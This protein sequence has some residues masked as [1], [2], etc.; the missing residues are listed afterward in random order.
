MPLVPPSPDRRLTHRFHRAF[1]LAIVASLAA[2]VPA[3]PQF[4]NVEV[5]LDV[6]NQ[7]FVSWG[8]TDADET[9]S[10]SLIADLNGDGIG[11]LV[12]GIPGGRGPSDARG[13]RT[14]EI[15][16]RFGTK[17][18][19]TAEDLFTRP[20]DV[21]LYGVDPGDQLPRSL[22]AGDLNG[23]GRADLVIG[24]SLADG[25]A[26]AR[27]GCGEVLVL[28]GRAAWPAEIDL[29]NVD[30]S[31]TNADVT[32]FGEEDGDQFG[33]SVA[34]GDL[35]GDGTD[36]LAVGA[37]GADGATNGRDDS[38]KAYVFYGGALPAQIDL[39]NAVPSVE[40]LGRDEG[41]LSGRSLAILDFNGDGT[42][43]LAI[44]AP[45]GDGSA[46]T[47]REDSGEVHVLFG[48]P[49]LPT[50]V[51]LR[52]GSNV[53]V[54]GA[55]EADLA[56]SS[57]AGGNLNGDVRGDLVVGSPFADGPPSIPRSAAGEVA[58]V[59]G[60]ETPAATIDLATAA[61]VRVYGA[62]EGDQLGDA[63][64]V[65]SLDGA[66]VYF[67]P[68][69][70]CDVE[71]TID[72]L[73]MTA[74]GGDGPDG[75]IPERTSAGEIYV[76]LGKDQEFA[77]FP[78]SY[79]LN[80]F[81]T[82]Q[83]DALFYGRDVFDS[84][85][86]S[87]ATGDADGDGIGEI[88][89]GAADGDGPEDG[90]GGGEDDARPA[91]GEAWL[92]S[93]SD[94]DGD[95]LRGLGDNCPEDYNPNQFDSD[96]DGVGNV[97]DNCLSAA[98]P[99]QANNDGDSEGDA[100]DL[101]DDNDGI[102]DASDPCPFDAGSNSDPDGDGFGD[103][104]DNCPAVPNPGQENL[105]GDVEGDACDA[106]DD[107][108][109]V[110]DAS[111]NCPVVSN[112]DQANGDADVFGDVCDNCASATNGGQEDGDADGDGD[113]C[114]NCPVVSNPSQ[115][116]TDG[117][118]DGDAC[119]NCP[120]AANADQLDADADGRGDVCD[121]CSAV[122]NLDQ[123]DSDLDGLGNACD[124]CPLA[125]N[126]TQTD[127][128]ADGR[129][130]ACDNCVNAANS[131]QA[132]LDGDSVG[133]VCDTDRDG[134]AATND[135][136]NCP[137]LANPSQFNGDAD[138]LGD[139]CDNCPAV[140]N[141][142]Q[143]DTDGDSFG[144][145][146][147]NC[148][149]FA[150][151]NQRNND[152]DPLGDACDDDDDGDGV[153]DPADNCPYASNP[154]QEDDDGDGFGNACDFT[155]IDLASSQG[156]V[157][158][159][160]R[161]PADFLSNAVL[162]ADVDGDGLNDLIFS[163]TAASGPSNAR[164]NAGE[165]NILFGRRAW[166][167]E[168]DLATT[169]PDVRIFGVDAKDSLGGAMAAGDFNGDGVAD[170]AIAARF[171]DGASN[172]KPNAG[173]VY[174]LFGRSRA[175][176]PATID[177]KSADASRSNADVT[178]F[179][180]DEGDQAGRSLAMGDVNGD[181]F[182]DVVLGATGG[183][184]KNN[185]CARCGD[186][187]IVAG[188]A[189]PAATYDLA[190]TGG[191]TTKLFG[192]FE[193][194][195]FGWSVATLDFDGDGL[196][197]VAVGALARD[198]NLEEDTGRVYVVRGASNLP[199]ERNMALGQFLVA[200]DGVDALDQFG[201]SLA[202]GEF[203]DRN[204]ACPPCEDLVVGAPTGDGPS[205]SDFRQD[206]G[207]VFVLRGRSDLSA[208]TVFDL[209]AEADPPEN[210]LVSIHGARA[211][212]RIG[213]KV[214]AGDLDG[215]LREDV[216]IGAPLSEVDAARPA[217]GRAVVYYGRDPWPARIDALVTPPELEVL[218]A[219]ALDDFGIAIGVGDV[220]GDGFGDALLAADSADGP[221]NARADAGAVH[222]VS[223]VDTDG[224][225][226]R[227]LG[228]LCPELANPSQED[229]DGDGRGDACDNCP[230]VINVA[231]E[232]SD[233]D[234]QGDACDA[235]DDNDGAPDVS[236]NCPWNPNADQAN[237]DGDPVGDI[238]DNCDTVSN[239]AQTD[240]DGDSEGDLCDAD[241][242]N[243]GDAD[244]SDN[245][246]LDP[247]ADQADGD[248]DGKGNLC[249]N[250]PSD[251]NADQADG[252]GDGKGNVC[253]NCE[254]VANAGQT[255]ADQ[256]GVG[257]GCDN[258]PERVN[259]GQ[260]DQ[261]GDGTGD[262]CDTDDDADG[263][264]DDGDVSGSAT[265]RPCITN[266]TQRCDD[267][268]R[269]DP[270]PTQTD[271]DGDGQGNACDGDDDADGD[272]DGSDNCPV[273]ANA[274]QAD[275][276]GDGVGTACDNCP[277]TPNPDQANADGDADGDACDNDNDNDGLLDGSDNCPNVANADQ[278]DAD[279]DGKGNACDNCP[280]LANANQADGDADARGDLCDNCPAASNPGQTDTDGDLQGDACDT[281]DDADGVPDASDNC[282]VVV[283]PGQ[284]DTV[285]EDG[286]GDDCDNCPTVANLDQT[287]ADGDG[288]G[289]AC[290]NCPTLSNPAQ[291]DLDGDGDGDLC[292][293]DDD[294]D[295]VP[296]VNDNCRNASNPSQ[297]DADNDAIGDVC[298]VCPNLVDPQQADNDADGR[299]NL[300]DNCPDAPNPDQTDTDGDAQGL[301][302]ACDPDD[303]NDGRL[304][305]A[306]NCRTI[307]NFDQADGDADGVGNVCDNCVG[308]PNAGQA[309]ADGD[310]LGDACDNCPLATNADQANFDGDGEGDVC[311]P[312]DDN[313]GTVDAADCAPFD[314][315]RSEV[316]GEATGLLW[317]SDTEFGWTASPQADTHT[318]YR[319]T[320]PNA[321]TIVYDHCGF[322]T[323]GT[324]WTD[325]GIPA[326]RGWYYLVSGVNCF[327][328]GTLGAG[329]GGGPRPSGPPC[330]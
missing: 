5:D 290:D 243:D 164:A 97:C 47:P 27:A 261:D 124:N 238:C 35:N 330:P 55:R 62:D 41:D 313:D 4:A 56:G 163:A 280:A 249:D 120:S 65:G 319:G 254:I 63:V 118:G 216:V 68:N 215:D 143:E 22:A 172:L 323:A 200:Y 273:V 148:P 36:D 289:D 202:T 10:G 211:E 321:G 218:G 281:D 134:D 221:G 33:R 91:A 309:N 44:G 46:T 131:D 325:A 223:P 151:P 208:G 70:F 288:L 286:V 121:N 147:D 232:D 235:D 262:D 37:Q 305:G 15:A 39:F 103:A 260:E 228:D 59:F 82:G 179:G 219:D 315:A 128:D 244:G 190:A 237:A 106:D 203:G 265:D 146:C 49:T 275:G 220:N 105:D 212:D 296:D 317:T 156:Y 300:C 58:I 25:P 92:L 184:G 119:D 298:D 189:S 140:D 141:A 258:C 32:I 102:P 294:G 89:T 161:D 252:D 328:E 73:V 297:A 205:A 87:L 138:G 132:D 19:P 114:D 52:T 18:Y 115:A 312:D 247:N 186:A 222:L 308:A 253:D 78:P 83:V 182:A 231:Q 11:D 327:G 292:D 320:I 180:A 54:H 113:A 16:I 299:G 214:G 51:D 133:N 239:P 149:A 84:I 324:T 266:Q 267:N 207:E 88:L 181:G 224:D 155:T 108:D 104:C 293:F 20:P 188:R 29:R 38:G 295:G 122:A 167:S 116:D 256:D 166:L 204:A 318:V 165:V 21:V 209:G 139:A 311:D 277:T 2:S 226:V 137:D 150:N 229:A 64:A 76:L 217:A 174:V 271:T 109:G 17:V 40:I 74:L 272:L 310:L 80:D 175:S 144:D 173:E 287:D 198:R 314:A 236:D 193:D 13:A 171:A 157:V 268:C 303:D 185:Q 316:P 86:T 66:T 270:N 285:D 291:S 31:T 187:Y 195:F 301:G 264:L 14:G 279:T 95:G 250:C 75:F 248:G 307:S 177:L 192:E 85:G 257:D 135:V 153:L 23:D 326:P 53:V 93:V 125:A 9:G 329:Q 127:G 199:A 145:A 129:G 176:W 213:E 110:A 240:T 100:C 111:D 225:G 42:L 154:L 255:D 142:G 130:D 30:P 60:H 160:G 50:I 72:D 251:A 302:D 71:R 210:A 282:P 206:A 169:L 269:L 259:A 201:A 98:N 191:A 81:F 242:D 183:D 45:G 79:D 101:D 12:V 178:I 304:D 6:D 159:H 197:D 48:S 96:A 112:A 90:P 234:G 170:V 158:I 24:V 241:D 7:D 227:N 274:D 263:V 233:A 168:T 61:S 278:A 126:A 69:C 8:R 26:N 152:G 306:D 246:P 276:D 1:S 34:V 117:D 283:N 99:A 284:L 162:A 77:S 67:D 136:D 196:D 322:P 123:V 230:A 107:A 3:L 28:Y 94:A 57:V 43:D 194:D 245:C